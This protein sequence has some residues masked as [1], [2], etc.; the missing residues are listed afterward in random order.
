MCVML[1][2]SVP[3]A[4]QPSI[5]L[6]NNPLRAKDNLF[7]TSHT[8]QISKLGSQNLEDRLWENNFLLSPNMCCTVKFS[9]LQ[10]ALSQLGHV[11]DMI[12]FS[13]TKETSKCTSYSFPSS[14]FHMQEMKTSERR[15]AA[16]PQVRRAMC[17]AAQFSSTQ[18]SDHCLSQFGCTPQVTTRC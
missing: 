17:Q 7:S 5:F 8:H 10:G 6:K 18:L 2:H 3:L 11:R 16:V 14:Q 9:R 13:R 4:M 12:Y 1:Y 15:M